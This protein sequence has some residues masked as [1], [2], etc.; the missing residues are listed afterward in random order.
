MKDIRQDLI[1]QKFRQV[2][3]RTQLDE[4]YAQMHRR[5]DDLEQRYESTMEQLPHAIQDVIRD[6]V[7]LCEAMSDRMIECACEE[8]LFP[9]DIWDD[10]P[11]PPTGW[12]ACRKRDM[13]A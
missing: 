10:S 2:W 12:P 4:D 9:D 3:E 8:I 6:Y 5:M 11:L 1:R 7:S 13:K